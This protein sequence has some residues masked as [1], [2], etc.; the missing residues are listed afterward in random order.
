MIKIPN[1]QFVDIATRDFSTLK[2]TLLDANIGENAIAIAIDP[3]LS[4]NAVV[5][6]VDTLKE[7]CEKL[8][9]NPKIPYPIFIVTQHPV[10][11]S[12]FLFVKNKDNISNYYRLK[13]KKLKKRENNLLNKVRTY[14]TR[15]NHY[16]V[17]P[18]LEALSEHSRK[19]K[20]LK[21]ACKEKA[22]YTDIIDKIQESKKR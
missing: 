9:V 20:M 19:H 1:L 7:V 12:D 3:S 17:G 13:M 11:N 22:F 5:E 4:K 10:K 2:K 18:S 16:R 8:F 21:S 15:I 6:I 14:T